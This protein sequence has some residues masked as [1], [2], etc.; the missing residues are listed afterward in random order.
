M[1]RVLT[2]STLFPDA[3]RP[4]FGVFVERQTLGLAAHPGVD[5]RVVAP[6]G[7]PPGPLRLMPRFAPLARLPLEETWRGVGVQR[8]RFTTIP[9]TG[10]RWHAAALTRALIPVLDAVRSDFP[11]DVIDA[12]FFFP[13]GVAA[14]ALGRRYGVPVSIKARGADIHHW[15]CAAGTRE[16]IRRAGCAADGLLAVSAAMRADMIAMGMPGAR[17]RVHHTGVDQD[18]F[19]PIDA[20]ARAAE[21]AR[22]G[23]TGPLVLSVGA[24]IPRKGH[25]VVI[26]AV[27]RLPGVSLRIAGEGGDRARLEAL[28]RTLGVGDRV[29]LLGSVAHEAI[30]RL[31]ATADVMALASASE[32]LAN[33]WVEALACGTPI[34]ITD[35]G[36]AGEVVTSGEAGRIVPRDAAA[37]GA[38]IAGI[39]AAPPARE[40]TR[41]VAARFT[42]EA[43]SAALFAHLAGLVGGG[44]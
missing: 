25:D 4:N 44:A 9:A 20:A 5:L 18:R 32:G 3:S 24:L 26:E 41:R 42:W 22:L 14:V 19:R 16:Q 36:G 8:P 17:I 39:L 27:A 10:G 31:V 40:A 11:F 13:D 23:V 21:A 1:M 28:I 37:F 2:L 12:S 6:I 43:N 15:G 30:P 33:A 35:A 34:V 38:A 29:R 7:L